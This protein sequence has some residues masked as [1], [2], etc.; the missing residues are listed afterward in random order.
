MDKTCF[1]VAGA[2][3][4]GKT[5]FAQSYLPAEAGCSVFI[6]A[7]MI[8]KGLSPFRPESASLEAGRIF[9][10]KIA[11][12]SHQGLSFAFESTLS[13]TGHIKRILDLKELGY[14]VAIY[15]LTVES[16]ELARMRVKTRVIE[17]GHDIPEA[18]LRRRFGRSWSNFVN[19]YRP[20]ADEWIVFD[21]SGHH[22]VII[23]RSL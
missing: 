6:N 23:E 22:P 10:G 4:A 13:G 9:L 17:G 5:S 8:A 14:R 1:I 15:Y 21:N 3:G 20:L 19:L 16:V 11:D 12:L 7:D 2:N 18:D